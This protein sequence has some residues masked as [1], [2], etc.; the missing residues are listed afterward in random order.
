MGKYQTY[1]DYTQTKTDWLGV[2]PSHWQIIPVGRL[3]SRIKR[4]DHIDKELLSVY[5]DYGVIPKSSRDDNNNKPS[6]D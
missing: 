1:P 5:R 2:C 4:T 3:F 6:E